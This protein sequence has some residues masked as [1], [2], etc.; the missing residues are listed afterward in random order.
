MEPS[1]QDSVQDVKPS[2]FRLKTPGERLEAAVEA[3]ERPT[4]MADYPM[5]WYRRGAGP[6]PLVREIT[7]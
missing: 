2:S 4:Q 7:R 3:M 6:D 5:D 1:R